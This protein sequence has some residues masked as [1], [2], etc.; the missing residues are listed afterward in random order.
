MNES[1]KWEGFKMETP[2]TYRI[3]VQGHL[4]ESRSD[5]LGGMTITPFIITDNPP[6]T[7]LTGL[8]IDQAALSGVLN[9]LYD[10]RMPL[11]SAEILD[12]KRNAES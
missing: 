8:L 4:D 10:M 1:P 11:L 12:E 7:V 9:T 5:W 6:V 3:R 2:V